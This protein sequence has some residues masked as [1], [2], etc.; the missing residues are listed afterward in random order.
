M[1]VKYYLMLLFAVFF[2][3]CFYASK[4]TLN[5]K[6]NKNQSKY[7][8]IIYF[9]L[10]VWSSLSDSVIKI[11]FNILLVIYLV[12]YIFVD[13]MN[14][15]LIFVGFIIFI[16]ALSIP[17]EKNFKKIKKSINIFKNNNQL[18]LDF[19]FKNIFFWFLRKIYF[20]IKSMKFCF[21]GERTF[22]QK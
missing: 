15:L 3:L 12:F 21:S 18:M 1:K 6:L 17:Y 16:V 5:N 7:L 2:I 20:S 13:L 19:L 4:A 9:L 11:L 8:L 10:F 14:S 22:H